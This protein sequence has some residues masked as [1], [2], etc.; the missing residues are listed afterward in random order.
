MNT[1]TE[2]LSNGS[3]WYGQKPDTIED[4][5]HNLKQYPLDPIFESY[6]DFVTL[7][8]P[9]KWTESNRKYKGFYVIFGNFLHGAG[10]FRIMT[11][12]E[13]LIKTVT[14]LVTANKL[15]DEYQQAKHDYEESKIR[16]V[17]TKRLF[18]GNDGKLNEYVR[19]RHKLGKGKFSYS[20]CFEI[21]NRMT[22]EELNQF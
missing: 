5:L 19:E 16:E 13:T 2:I 4:F 11:N 7:Y 14:E 1:V 10:V 6:G 3:K 18:H 9:I 17:V 15:M 20:Q 12:D 8:N 22:L 21:I